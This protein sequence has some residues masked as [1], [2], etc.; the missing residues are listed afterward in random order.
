MD[1]ARGKLVVFEGLDRSGKSTQVQ[2]LVD[3]LRQK[4]EKVEQTRF[5]N[6]TTLI[7]QMINNYLTG[8]SQQDDHAI[9]LL[10][11]ANRWESAQAIEDHINAG[12]TVVIDRYYCSGCV[13]SAAKQN[14]NISLAWCREPEVGLPRPDLC[15]FLDIST[16]ETAKRGGFGIERYEKAE[17]QD[18]VRELYQE[19]RAHRDEAEDVVVVDAGR[20]ADEVE[21]DVMRFVE[22]A[23]VKSDV[24]G[25]LR[26]VRPW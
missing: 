1:T 6:R 17:V 22:E 3:T 8:T 25:K 20:T 15:L 10:F 24:D 13:Y 14:P 5:P 23:E 2:R 19:M 11:T 21:R 12:T 18:R 26:R 7:G 4:G 9:H 16:E